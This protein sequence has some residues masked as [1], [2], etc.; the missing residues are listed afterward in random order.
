[1]KKFSEEQK[2]ELAEAVESC[3]ANDRYF[4]RVQAVYWRAMGRK[5]KDVADFSGYNERNISRLCADYMAK[6]LKGLRTKSKCNYRKM[7]YEAE[8]EVLAKLSEGAGTGKYVRVAE[9]LKQFEEIS[10]VTYQI[11]AFYRLLWRHGWRKVMPRGQHPKKASDEDIES[12][13]K[14]TSH[15]SS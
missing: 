12:S 4:K 6:G 10:K 5:L 8:T 1:M 7:S 9:L 15:S 13:K 11:D 2:R 3:E 14:L